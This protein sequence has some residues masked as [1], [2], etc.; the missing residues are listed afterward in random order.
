MLAAIARRHVDRDVYIKLRHL[1]DENKDHLHREKFSYPQ[2]I[3]D[4]PE[5]LPANLKLTACTMDEAIS[6]AG[7]GVTCTST[8]AIDLLRSGL[9]TLIT[10]DY[11]EHYLDPM[12]E[13]MERLFKGSGL[14]APLD[15]VLNL[16]V[17]APVESWLN[18]MLCPRDLGAKVLE[19]IAEAKQL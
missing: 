7:I 16:K 1:P 11:V 4:W 5:P 13:Q 19:A 8:A 18:N 9:P 12:A 17:R 10:L 15:E 6:R 3:E 14:I 2:I